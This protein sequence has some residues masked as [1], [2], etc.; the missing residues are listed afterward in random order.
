LSFD[1]VSEEKMLED[2]VIHYMKIE[3]MWILTN[4]MYAESKEID[5][6]LAFKIEKNLVSSDYM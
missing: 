2:Q 5:D 1:S 6:I 4:L 3:A